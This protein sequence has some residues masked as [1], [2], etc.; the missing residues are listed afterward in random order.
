MGQAFLR[1][2]QLFA[3]RF[4]PE[5]WLNLPGMQKL[6]GNATPGVSPD[7]C[8]PGECKLSTCDIAMTDPTAGER[9]LQYLSDTIRPDDF[10]RIAI[11]GFNVVRLPLGY[12]NVLD[13]EAAPDAPT[14][15]AARWLA[16][17][18]MLPASSYT[19]HIQRTLRYAEQHGLRVLL[20]LH[21]A[22]GGRE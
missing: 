12:W 7:L 4:I 3:G 13:V 19:P 1:S 8:E 5:R 6:Y 10:E 14:H 11:E 18:R 22:P 2:A 9:M 15:D 20:D 21:G 16:L 17:Q